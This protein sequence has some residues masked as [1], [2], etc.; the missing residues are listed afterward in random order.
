[1]GVRDAVEGQQQG[2]LPQLPTSIDQGVEIKGVGSRRL[3]CDALMDRTTRDL[4]KTRPGDLLH[5]DTRTLGIAK[6]LQK[7][8]SAS[9]FWRAPDAMDGSPR[10]KGRQTGVTAPDQIIGGRGC[11]RCLRLLITL[12]TWA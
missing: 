6:Q 2:S 1:M 8:C 9:H 3:Q 4:T 7:F 12:E 10:F 11:S 5:Q